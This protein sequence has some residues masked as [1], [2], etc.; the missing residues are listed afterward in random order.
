MS[1]GQ[2]QAILRDKDLIAK[3]AALHQAG[4]LDR[5]ADIYR[6]VLA[7]SP[8]NFDA[9]HLLGVVA[10]QQ[11]KYDVAQ[12]VINAAL[13]MRPNDAAAMVNLGISYLR[14]G[15]LE[16][17]RQWFEIAVKCQPDSPI[18]LTNAAE[19]LYHMGRHGDAIPLL[20]KACTLDPSSY[21]A[22]NL[23]G[24]CLMKTGN[25]RAAATPFETATKL[26]PGD[27]EAW[28]NLSAAL[29]AVGENERARDCVDRAARLQPSSPAALNALAK[30]QFD[31]GRISESIDSFRRGLSLAAPSVD[32]I[33]SYTNALLANGLNEAAIEQLERALVLDGKSLT[34]RWALA[35]AQLKAVYETESE[36][37]ASRAAFGKCLD[38][39]KSW[40]E[41]TPAI[42]APY[43]TVGSVQPFALA[44][45]NY[46]NRDLLKR[47]GALCTAFMATLPRRVP[48]AGS[49]P[50][51][52][53][54]RP[55][56]R[57]VR[58]G[59]V[60]AHIR[61]HSI[62]IAVTK[63]WLQHLDR[64]MFEILVFH[65]HR[66]VDGETEALMRSVD[67]FDNRTKDLA[68]WVE[69]I[70]ERELDVILYPEIGSDSLTVKLAS[71]RLAPVQA[72]TW[73]H[74]E[75]SGLPTIDLY[76]SAQAFEPVDSALNN[77]SE[78]LVTLPHLSVY[79]EPLALPYTDPDLISLKLPTDQALLLCPG[80][81]F[82]YAPQYDDVW[83]QIAKGL[84][85]KYFFRKSSAGRLIFFRS[86]NDTLDRTL[87][88]RLRAAFARGGIDFDA[89]ASIIPFLDHP[90]FFGLMRRSSLMLDTLGF[91]GFNTAL[92]GIECDL[93]VLAFEGDF[94][95]GRLAS[96]ILRELELPEL[97]AASTDDFVHKAVTLAKNPEHLR[98]LKSKVVERRARL[99]R[100]LIPVR[101][102][103]R[104][105]IDACAASHKSP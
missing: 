89:H 82:K 88:Q 81:P 93:P 38:D 65:L 48:G 23:L 47:Y 80:Q 105:L 67:H 21:G 84:Q 56:G 52:S 97:V 54:G 9:T 78:K 25:E 19:V 96:G 64:G 77:Y 37:A 8:Q 87:E 102:L 14:D 34:V 29:K 24:A 53:A 103:E 98:E 17:A 2:D 51:G 71:L 49:P 46:N 12:R 63:G 20:Q 10:L 91:S 4:D 75:T 26:R 45:Q 41:R 57:K 11:G 72:V 79:V 36:V 62:W 30:A 27:A 33:L 16:P 5:A 94:M 70:S 76:F 7:L 99:F 101:A 61:E 15:Q 31:Q 1:G 40:Y 104:C 60:S 43:N 55:A 6:E 90:R 85:R 22:H 35:L 74:P 44:Y 66:I 69:C 58:L 83:V 28:A 73:G 68:G 18:A 100:N 13:V 50:G 42:E 59:V 86:Q 39:I 32:M 95:R 3:A 92:Q